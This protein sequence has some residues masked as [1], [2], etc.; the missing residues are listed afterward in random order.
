MSASEL[1]PYAAAGRAHLATLSVVFTPTLSPRGRMLAREVVRAE[2]L[3]IGRRELIQRWHG[4]EVIASW[5][6]RLADASRRLGRGELSRLDDALQETLREIRQLADQAEQCE[7][8]QQKRLYLLTA[9]RQTCAELGLREVGGAEYEEP[10]RRDG[11]ILFEVDTWNGGHLVI[12]L[13]LDRIRCD[14]TMAD[15]RRLNLFGQL[16]KSLSEQFGI[17][18][19]FRPIEQSEAFRGGEGMPGI[20]E[21][22]RDLLPCRSYGWCP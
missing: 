9:L 15:R 1:E 8:E 19:N 7:R 4:K 2:E 11:R 21:N 17:Q 10:H 22:A 18:T 5:E 12:Y 20:Q 14:W 13:A 16:S 3:L 6:A